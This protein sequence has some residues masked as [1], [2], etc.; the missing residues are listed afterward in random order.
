MLLRLAG[1][2]HSFFHSW[3]VLASAVIRVYISFIRYNRLYDALKVV[4][5]RNCVQRFTEKSNTRVHLPLWDNGH[6]RGEWKY[7]PG[8]SARH[9]S[10]ITWTFWT[11]TCVTRTASHA[12]RNRLSSYRLSPTTYITQQMNLPNFVLAREL[13]ALAWFWFGHLCL[14]CPAGAPERCSPIS[15]STVPRL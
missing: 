14:H 2:H 4:G 10:S 6:T 15:P 12:F 3:V 11:Q 9:L 8:K 13:W 5:R 1:F 7:K